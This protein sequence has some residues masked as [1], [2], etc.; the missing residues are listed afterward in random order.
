MTKTR[1][2][3]AALALAPLL[4]AAQPAPAASSA[5][6]PRAYTRADIK[7]TACGA[8]G[9]GEVWSGPR[10]GQIEHRPGKP[11]YRVNENGF[12]AVGCKM[13]PR[14]KDCQERP[15]PAWLVDGRLCQ[16]VQG[17][18]IPARN[19]PFSH[20]VKT[21]P[22]LRNWGH[23][24]WRCRRNEDGTRGWVMTFQICAGR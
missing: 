21:D 24:E 10:K 1:S 2:L 17:R 16:P 3:I 6:A 5:S 12:W 9:V 7:P 13:P 8:E 22:A 4:A 23:Q 11:G 20:T 14:P 18:M 19:V 15:A